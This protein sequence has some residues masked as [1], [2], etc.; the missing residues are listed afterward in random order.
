MHSIEGNNKLGYSFFG[1]CFVCIRVLNLVP[2]ERHRWATTGGGGG[3]GAVG[4]MIPD[5]LRNSDERA[6]ATHPGQRGSPVTY[7]NAYYGGG[8][9]TRGREGPRGAI[10]P[11][12]HRESILPQ[13]MIC[14]RSFR[15]EVFLIRITSFRASTVLSALS[16]TYL[17]GLVCAMQILHDFSQRQA[18][19]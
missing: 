19:N 8:V 12:G 5:C 11:V 9:E 10:L 14:S 1:S 17:L 18:R 13:F 2:D 6:P 15:A 3:V 4:L 7:M 16:S